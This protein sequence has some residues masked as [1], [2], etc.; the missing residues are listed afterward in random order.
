[1]EFSWTRYL[2]IKRFEGLTIQHGVK[3]SILI[4]KE[5]TFWI[6]SSSF[7]FC[8][9]CKLFIWIPISSLLLFILSIEV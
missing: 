9:F 8:F 1:L 5:C 7:Y 2:E 4:Y 6:K 3:K